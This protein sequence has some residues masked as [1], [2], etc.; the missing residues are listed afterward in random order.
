MAFKIKSAKIFCFVFLF[1]FWNKRTHSDVVVGSSSTFEHTQGCYRTS[2]GRGNEAL[3][4][5]EPA[6]W[7]RLW[8]K[9]TPGGTA[10]SHS[11]KAAESSAGGTQRPLQTRPGWGDRIQNFL[12]NLNRCDG[13][14]RRANEE[15][16]RWLQAEL[17]RASFMH[18]PPHCIG[19]YRCDSSCWL[20]LEFLA[21]LRHIRKA[22]FISSSSS[23][24]SFFVILTILV[25]LGLGSH[26]HSQ[27]CQVF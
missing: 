3:P 6:G 4:H 16:P 13:E 21:D 27:F 20:P 14:S 17:E 26:F 1:F 25:L 2:T 23:S 5:P 19:V 22:Q 7:H 11:L 12:V 10:G 8:T 24:L 15:Q 18:A 9:V